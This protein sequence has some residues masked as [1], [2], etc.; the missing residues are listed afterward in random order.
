MKTIYK[1][2]LA[3]ILL[4]IPSLVFAADLEITC[5]QDQK[6]VIKSNENSL[7]NIQNFLPGKTEVRTVTIEN[8]DPENLCRIYFKGE[9]YKNTLTENM[10]FAIQDS[11]GNIVDR[12]A[13]SNKNVS[14]F[15]SS[16][17][18]EIASVNSHQTVTK[19]IFL[20]FNK[21]AD[22]EIAQ[23]FTNFDIRII[24]EWGSESS[25]DQE[26]VLG[27]TNKIK[28][29]P[30]PDSDVTLTSNGIG[31]PD[32][33]SND[34]SVKGAQTCE[35]KIK[36]SGFVY[37]DKNGD[38]LKQEKEPY[39]RNIKIK[40][41]TT[42]DGQQETIVDLVTNQVGY[43][44][45]LLCPGDYSIEIERG[46]LPENSTLEENILSLNI[47]Q[48]ISYKT[49]NIPIQENI[50]WFTT[51]WA[52]ILLVAVLLFISICTY[53]Y[54]RIKRSLKPNIVQKV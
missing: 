20:T 32:E 54:I 22:N 18:I 21:D 28:N 2:T 47:P 44:K 4:L 40:I 46:S 31:G 7:F 29:D 26:D 30:L 52:W 8:K 36:A 51:Y 1:I 27:A 13:T 45:T 25:D 35:N 39:L 6:P 38:G 9:G 23:I 12:Q 11:F 42:I 53:I 5:Y 43:W 14:D 16:E 48:N 50:S 15:L 37:L 41:Y 10:Y 17:K 33:T 49:T 19:E 34:E 24:S 3:S